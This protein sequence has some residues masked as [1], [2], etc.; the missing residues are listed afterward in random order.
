M[1]RGST[2]LGINR[3]LYCE[4]SPPYPPLSLTAAQVLRCRALGLLIAVLVHSSWHHLSSWWAGI[5]SI[6]DGIIAPSADEVHW[7]GWPLCEHRHSI[8]HPAVLRCHPAC[9]RQFCRTVPVHSQ[10]AF[11]WSEQA[12]CRQDPLTACLKGFLFEKIIRVAATPRAFFLPLCA[13][14]LQQLFFLRESWVLWEHKNNTA[15]IL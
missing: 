3:V 12:R 15:L 1:Q 13:R 10:F 14:P 2:A 7:D 4:S 9:P 5:M 11:G 6:K 8:E